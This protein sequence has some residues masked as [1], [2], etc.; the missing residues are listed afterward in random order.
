MPL[1]F[2]ILFLSLEPKKP[3]SGP[4]I[5]HA[6][7]YS[8]GTQREGRGVRNPQLTGNRLS[9]A[10]AQKG[11]KAMANLLRFP[12]VQAKTGGLS[13]STIWR[14]ERDGLFPKRRLVTGKMV[15]WDESE[16]DEW[17]TSRRQDFGPAPSWNF[18]NTKRNHAETTCDKGAALQSDSRNAL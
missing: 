1:K 12:G 8:L 13:R 14:L 2:T 15:A 4:M 16:I 18:R 6:R 17:I 7:K 9:P 5:L 3:R 10:A 11:A